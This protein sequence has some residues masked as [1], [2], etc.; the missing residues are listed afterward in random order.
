MAYSHHLAER[1]LDLFQRRPFLLAFRVFILT[2]AVMQ[3]EFRYIVLF[4]IGAS[5]WIIESI[6]LYID[7]QFARHPF[8]RLA[9]MLFFVLAIS[10]ALAHIVPNI[11]HS[12]EV[13]KSD[14]DKLK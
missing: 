8:I 11:A 3:E 2:F 5:I 13:A 6:A 12:V 1:T 14:I 4:I 10:V 7:P 9:N